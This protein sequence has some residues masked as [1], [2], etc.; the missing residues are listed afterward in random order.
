[1]VSRRS[2][3]VAAVLIGR[4]SDPDRPWGAA[5]TM[6]GTLLLV[7]TPNYPWY[8]LLLVA[9]VVLDGRAEWLAVGLAGYGIYFTWTM[10]LTAEQIRTVHQSSYAAALV[11]VVAA[12]AIRAC[13]RRTRR[14]PSPPS[15][16]APDSNVTAGS[17]RDERHTVTS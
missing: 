7:L 2:L 13:P 14:R 15:G 5:L 11:T 3:L 8:A 12:T 6:T 17:T 10:G 16:R 9:L 4:R 1:M